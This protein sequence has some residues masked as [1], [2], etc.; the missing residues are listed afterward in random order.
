MIVIY[1]SPGCS[2]CR[3]VRAWL[4]ERNLTYV[5]KNIFTTLLN[6]VEIKHLLERSENGTDDIISKRSKIMKNLKIDLDHLSINELIQFI[7]ANPS[8]LK[9]PIILNERVFQ[10]GY[11][12]EEI[13]AFVPQELRKI[14]VDS[15]NN[16]CPYYDGCGR[17]REEDK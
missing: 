12:E 4:K 3:K 17:V 9:R 7:Q 13:D 16:D 6:E 14:A 5:E 15:C 11:D 8:I 10:V 2:S 1:T